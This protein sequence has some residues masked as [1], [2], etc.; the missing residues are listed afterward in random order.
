M[1]IGVLQCLSSFKSPKLEVTEI[2]TKNLSEGTGVIPG[3]LSKYE[4]KPWRTLVTKKRRF[5][6]KIYL[7]PH[8]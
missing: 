3:T 6:R 7:I 4:S 2:T 5:Q 1:H 8:Y